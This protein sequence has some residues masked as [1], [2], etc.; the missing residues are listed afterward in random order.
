LRYGKTTP[1]KWRSSKGYPAVVAGFFRQ[2]LS[3]ARNDL[4]RVLTPPSRVRADVIRQF[5]ER[6]NDGIVAVLTELGADELLRLHVIDVL[7]NAE[8]RTN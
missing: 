8:E 7:R 6:G 2:L 1:S 4:L 3:S 5:H